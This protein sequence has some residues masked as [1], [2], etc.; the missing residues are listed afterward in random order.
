MRIRYG[1]NNHC[2]ERF[3]LAETWLKEAGRQAEGVV[4]HAPARLADSRDIVALA[5]ERLVAD[6]LLFLHAPEA[7][8][9][10]CVEAR[11]SVS[12]AE[13]IRNMG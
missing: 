2:C 10:E 11:Q 1:E 13:P 6:P 4:G 3:A 8:C 5:M 7:G 12:A 9:A